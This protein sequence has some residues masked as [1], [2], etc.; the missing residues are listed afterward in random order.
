MD[1]Y[2]AALERARKAYEKIPPENE[3]VKRLLEEAFP[4]LLD[5]EKNGVRN[6][7][8]E[9]LKLVGKGDGDYAQ[10]MIDKWIAYLEEEWSEE[11]LEMQRLLINYLGGGCASFT[12]NGVTNKDFIKWLYSIRHKAFNSNKLFYK[13]GQKS[14]AEELAKVIRGHLSC[15]KKDVQ[16]EIENRYLEVT[17]EKM[18]QGFND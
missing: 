15:I 1:K 16:N 13:K 2:E 8:I 9:Y 3:A 17:G 10:P 11:D 12:I 14:G 7:I 4:E 5:Y 18:Y 6:E